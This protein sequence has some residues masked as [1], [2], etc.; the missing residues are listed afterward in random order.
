MKVGA[1]VDLPNISFCYG[2][3][4]TKRKVNYVEYKKYVDKFGDSVVLNAYGIQTDG[5]AKEFIAFLERTGYET[6]FVDR[7]D[8]KRFINVGPTI[9]I[10]V[11]RSIDEYETVILGTTDPDMVPLIQW[12]KDQGKVVIIIAAD[13]TDEVKELCDDYEDLTDETVET[14]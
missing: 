5:R 7:T 9:V 3:K 12:C 8:Q 14:N 4:T 13:I 10:D 2:R 11:V 1:F 6:Y